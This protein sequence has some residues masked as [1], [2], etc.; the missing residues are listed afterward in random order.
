MIDVG[1]V[2]TFTLFCLSVLFLLLLHPR[3]C[4]ANQNKTVVSALLL[5]RWSNSRVIRFQI[6]IYI[7]SVRQP[8]ASLKLGT[9]FT[10]PAAE[11]ENGKAK[12]KRRLKSRKKRVSISAFSSRRS[13]LATCVVVVLLLL[14]LL[15]LRLS[16]CA[17]NF[18]SCCCCCCRGMEEIPTDQ[19]TH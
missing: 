13:A 10:F 9:F 11:A 19:L 18:L 6:L 15:F 5:L 14:L 2:F 4:S 7:S 1:S 8:L 17:V 12:E 16:L 3:V